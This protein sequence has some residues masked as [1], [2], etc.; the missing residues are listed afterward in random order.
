[1]TIVQ[2]KGV[3]ENRFF[4][5]IPDEFFFTRLATLRALA[6]AVQAGGLTAEQKKLFEANED[7]AVDPHDPNRPS[8]IP[9]THKEPCCPWFTCCY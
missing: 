3:L 4:C 6:E 7:T 9:I 1:M 5:D 8:T 2:F